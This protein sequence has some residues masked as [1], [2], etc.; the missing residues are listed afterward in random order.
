MPPITCTFLQN[1]KGAFISICVCNSCIL[2]FLLPIPKDKLNGVISLFLSYVKQRHIA[3][4]ATT[5]FS[6]G[7]TKSANIVRSESS[8]STHCN[9]RNRLCS[10]PIQLITDCIHCVQRI[11]TSLRH[12][13]LELSH[14]IF[15]GF[16]CARSWQDIVELIKQLFSPRLFQTVLSLIIRKFQFC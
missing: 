12:N 7:E 13:L 5:L 8:A 10:V 1:F 15:S 3:N 11:N 2:Q 16:D 14:G 6:I 4:I 9:I